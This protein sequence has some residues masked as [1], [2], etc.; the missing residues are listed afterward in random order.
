MA[1]VVQ[2]YQL[3]STLMCSTPPLGHAP[4]APE[5]AGAQAQ[6]EDVGDGPEVRK[7]A[8]RK[9]LNRETIGRL[10]QRR[11]DKQAPRLIAEGTNLT[12]DL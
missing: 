5:D 2:Y 3:V 1:A 7:I 8:R 6:D 11:R 4:V 9:S 12:D 10:I